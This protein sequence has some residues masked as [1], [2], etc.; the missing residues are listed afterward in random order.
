[1]TVTIDF[2]LITLIGIFTIG[3]VMRNVAWLWFL[4][5]VTSWLLGAYWVSNPLVTAPDPVDDIALTIA[6]LGGFGLMAMM[7]LKTGRGTDGVEKLSFSVK[8]PR[9]L[10]GRT[11]EEEIAMMASRNYRT[12]N[13]SYQD[14]LNNVGRR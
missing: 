14:R 9:F 5:G 4:A 7:G 13:R 12:R 10:G 3:A 11:E 6:F 1:M 2:A 8:L